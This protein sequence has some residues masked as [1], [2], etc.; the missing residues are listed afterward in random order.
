MIATRAIRKLR[1]MT[2]NM[3]TFYTLVITQALST[4]GTMMTS[5]ALGIWLFTETGSAMPLMIVAFCMTLPNMLLRSFA[6]IFAD[7]W[8][9]RKLM[10]A[11]DAA[12]ALPTL[13]LVIGFATGSI[14]LWQI[15]LATLIQAIFGMFQ[16][17]A[18][19]SS[20]TMLVPEHQRDRANALMGISGPLAGLIAPVIAGFLYVMVGVAGIMLIDLVTFLI[21]AGVLLLVKIPQP[22]SSSEG[23][24]ASGSMWKEL[25]GS[26][27]FLW[28]RPQYLRLILFFTFLNLIIAGPS[29]LSPAYIIAITGSEAAVGIVAAAFNLGLMAGAMGFTAMGGTQSRVR[30][31]LVGFM[32]VGFWVTVHGMM[33]SVPLLA[34]SAFLIT[35]PLV[36]AGSSMNALNQ[37]KVP[38]DMQG[39]VFS[40]IWQ[41]MD[42]TQPI[43]ML[44]TGPLID[45]ILE[46]AVGTTHWGIVAP[47]VGSQQGSGMGLL[48]VISGALLIS[49]CIL[50]YAQPKIRSLESDLPSYDAVPA[51]APA[52][53]T[54]ENQPA[55]A[56]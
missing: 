4:I 45:R 40:M 13:L 20:M 28:A 51:S 33:R 3:R 8:D 11:S 24:Q 32:I 41:I 30:T 9:R 10:V 52:G 5:L 53:D 25:S 34:F 39:R 7:H 55:A 46:P 29:R 6:G 18:F 49:G 37:A 12:Q 1:V 36:A 27:R 50:F 48:Y 16:G 14:S 54:P 38:P 15:Y 44:L 35:L 31:I 19:M 21:S 47:L 43:S 56:S 22:E 26:F 42:V 17:P 2:Y 23:R